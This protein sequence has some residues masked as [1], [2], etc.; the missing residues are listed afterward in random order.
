MT[1]PFAEALTRAQTWIETALEDRFPEAEGLDGAIRY[2]ILG[3]GK[4]LRPLLTREAAA[5]FGLGAERA[6]FAAMAIECLHVYSLVH[7]DMP[8]MDDDDMRRGR[9]T[10][11][12]VWDEATAVL[13]GDALQAEAFALLS[14]PRAHPDP[15]TRVAL[16]ADLAKAGGAAGMV[17]GQ[18]LDLAAETRAEPMSLEEISILQAKKTGALIRWSAV[19]GA[20]L[21]Q[22]DGLAEAG[23]I[24]AMAAYADAVGRAFQIRDDLLDVEGD[25]AEVGKA[26]GKDAA[27]GKAT[28]VSLLGVEG[29][30]KE[31]SR[32]I[33]AARDALSPYGGRAALLRALA[34]YAVLRR[35]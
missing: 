25:A 3:G 22:G 12:K 5:L 26:T 30:R 29:A 23:D 20:R 14:D 9:P 6:V 28:F 17:G 35:H 32:L 27:A 34:E 10:V 7:D 21:A 8:C 16:M 13:V 19:A 1:E 2:A 18:A 4:R 24:A 33:D 11:H 15:A 31:A